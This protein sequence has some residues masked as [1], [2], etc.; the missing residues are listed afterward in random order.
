MF[1]MQALVK[2]SL[3][4]PFHVCRPMQGSQAVTY[5]LA[6]IAP[7]EIHG[8][9]LCAMQLQEVSR[10]VDQGYSRACQAF[11]LICTKLTKQQL[12]MPKVRPLT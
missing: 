5:V 8:Y 7:S 1:V 2:T 12:C 6:R 11:S 4:A 9:K 3:T 10:W